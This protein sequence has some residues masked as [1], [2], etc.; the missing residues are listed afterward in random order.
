MKVIDIIKEARN[1]GTHRFSIEVLPPLKGDGLT[2]VFSAIDNLADHGPA[3]I[4]V[5]NHRESVKYVEYDNGLL[6]KRIVRRRPGTIGVSAAIMR[7]Y[8]VEVVPHLICGGHTRYDL[9]D[10]LIDLDFLGIQNVLALRGDA[11]PGAGR[12]EANKD[13]L[14]HADE[15]VR[16]IQDMNQGRFIDGEVEDCHHSEFCI[17]VAGYPEKHVES[18]NSTTDIE[19]LKRKVDAGA[20][21]IATQISYDA[22]K[23]IAFRDR[24]R[25]MGIEAEILPGIKPFSTKTQLTVLPQTFA[26]DLPQDLV[27]EVKKCKDNDAVRQV[28]IEWAVMQGKKLLDAGFPVLHFYTMTK[29]DNVKEIVSRLF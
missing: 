22:D 14:S 6:K 4:N 20:D 12:F 2:K 5:T 15:L 8:N 29:T 3:F 23:I 26:V 16:Q 27:N 7:R 24:C 11:M 21:Y 1:S 28:G 25:Q 13:G 19:Y 9:E 18:P 17:G 10:A